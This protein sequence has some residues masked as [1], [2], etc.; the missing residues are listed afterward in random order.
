MRLRDQRDGERRRRRRPPGGRG[1][2]P[3]RSSTSARRRSSA[4]VVGRRTSSRRRESPS[5]ATDQ[6]AARIQIVDRDQQLAEPRLPEIVG[7]HLDV[8]ARQILGRRLLQLRRAAQQIP[9]ACAS[10]CATACDDESGARMPRHHHGP[11]GARAS[12]DQ[13]SAITNS[14]RRGRARERPAAAATSGARP[15]QT[16]PARRA[17]TRRRAR[18]PRRRRPS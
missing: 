4:A 10:V 7:Q 9:D 15:A 16:P 18:T 12:C 5:S 14:R 11:R 1:P 3:A 13:P 17:R 2:I 8:A 6:V